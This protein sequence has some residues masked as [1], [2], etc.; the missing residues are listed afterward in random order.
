[1]RL[2]TSDTERSLLRA[3]VETAVDGILTIDEQGTI[4][5]ANSS[6]QRIFGYSPQELLGENV[7]VLMPSPYHGEHDGYLANYRTTGVRKVIGIGREVEG[8]RKDGTVL[9][10]DL[11]VSETRLESGTIFTGILRD[12]TDRKK[13]AIE[14]SRERALLK[15][16]V[17]TA[18]DAI[19]TIDE[20]GT[21]QTAN[22]AIEQMFGYSPVELIGKNVRTLMPSPYHEEHDGYL[23]NYRATGERKIIG[24]GRQVQGLRK[25]GSVFPIDLAVSETRTEGGRIFTGII[26]D[27]SD[28][29]RSIELQF[30][31]DAADK[32]NAAK[33]EFLS[34]MSH[35]LRTPLNAVLGFAQV[36]ALQYDDPRIQ[37]A[38][39]SIVK[40][41]Q[42]LLNLINEILDLSRIEAGQLSLSLEP[43]QLMA[44]IRQAIDLVHPLAEQKV[45]PSPSI[46]GRLRRNG[47]CGRPTEAPSGVHQ[48]ALQRGEV[49][50][51]GR[52][53]RGHHRSIRR[54]ISID[55]RLRYR[56]G[57]RGRAPR[58]LVPALRKVQRS[59]GRRNRARPRAF[60]AVHRADGRNA[61]T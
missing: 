9:S 13:A 51:P 14:I 30:A 37:E 5:S 15:A 19:L 20:N 17:D 21:I 4:L 56:G 53:G 34:R 1:M 31:K 33:S 23:A 7:R 38:T 36:M 27:I 24:I 52:T 41:G 54:E 60:L 45:D 29:I 3:V 58:A 57:N 50:P 55:Y 40:A 44:I 43:V 26:R 2:Y 22:P 47:G 39:H 59:G 42:H 16:V 49:Q 10:L 32:A 35:E 6:V 25:D 28:R 11:S 46:G 48:S 61:G 8:R 18:V 12:V